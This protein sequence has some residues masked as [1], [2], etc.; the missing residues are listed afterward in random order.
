[1]LHH[2]DE[3]EDIINQ[4]QDRLEP[5][6]L[7]CED[8]LPRVYNRELRITEALLGRDDIDEKTREFSTKKL[9][10]INSVL[11]FRTQRSDSGEVR[12]SG[13]DN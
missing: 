9:K 1:M 5:Y 2:L 3:D 13:V 6:I 8:A 10:A 4:S 11:S 7:S 12:K